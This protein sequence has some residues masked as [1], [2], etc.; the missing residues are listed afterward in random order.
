MIFTHACACVLAFCAE[1][2][3]IANESWELRMTVNG[4]GSGGEL[5]ACV[6]LPWLIALVLRRD[7]HLSILSVVLCARSMCCS[8]SAFVRIN[9]N[10]NSDNIIHVGGSERYPKGVYSI[11]GRVCDVYS[12]VVFIAPL[13]AASASHCVGMF[14]GTDRQL[15]AL[16]ALFRFVC[17][18]YCVFC[19]HGCET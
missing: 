10:Y 1:I 11:L 8:R 2:Q 16:R 14:V 13:R 5:C 19:V 4:S 7:S 15:Y 12:I 3:S 6:S 18:C 9:I 17:V